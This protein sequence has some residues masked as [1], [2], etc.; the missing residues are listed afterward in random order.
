MSDTSAVFLSEQE[1][2]IRDAARKVAQE[3]VAPTA[4]E[5][6]RTGAWPR[7][8]L[9]AIAALGYLGLHIPEE[10]GG[11]GMGFVEYCLVIEEFAAVDAGFATALHVHNSVALSIFRD[12]TEEQKR[13]WLPAMIRGERIGCFLLSEPH[14]GSD[15]AAFRTSARRE[16]DHYVLNG[17]KQFI[18]N[19]GEAGVAIVVSVT[20]KDAGKK[21]VS[22]IMVDPCT[23]GFAVTRNE[24]KMGQRTAN[25]AA[26]QMENCRVPVSN[27]LGAEGAGY[28][29]IIAG[30]DEGRV[31]IAALATGIARAALEAAVKYA[32]EREAYGAPIIDLQG[33]AFD[34]ADMATQVEVSHV[35]MLHAARLC[36]AG[37]RCSKEASAI[38][39]FASE[40]AEKVCSDALQIHGGY[41][42]LN[43][44][45]VERYYRDAR[46]TKIYEGT[47]HI[48]KLIIARNL[49]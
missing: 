20:N 29:H 36:Q 28:R 23:P 15:T 14:A 46:V 43:D 48:Q 24:E 7:D 10:Y 17:S 19:G 11:V 33:V 21:G 30:L 47:S 42:Y 44:F 5:R 31:A 41:G 37:I 35:Y 1:A 32:K 26:I 38:K 2:M 39:L 13:Q 12:G 8:E 49:G 9:N 16:G 45:P 4:A 40:M 22:L 27:L 25:L 6:D 3:V 34:L 18:S